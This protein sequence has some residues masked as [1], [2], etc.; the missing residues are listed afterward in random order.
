MCHYLNKRYL[1]LIVFLAHLASCKHQMLQAPLKNEVTSEIKPNILIFMTDDMTFSD[2]GPYG[3]KII[4]TPNLDAF[5]KQSLKFNYAFDSASM[6]APTRMALYTGLYPV[7]NGGHPNH[8]RVYDHVKSMPNY[9]RPL[10]YRVAITGKRHEAPQRNFSF[11]YIGGKHVAPGA[12][13][14]RRTKALN[15]TLIDEFMAETKKPWA[16]VV[17]S[18][19]PHGPWDKGDVNL[20]NPSEIEVPPDLVDTPETRKALQQ[21]Y[22][23]ITYA[24]WQFG[25]ILKFL[26]K[27]KQE[28]KTLVFFLSEQG[29]TFPFAKWTL[30]ESGVRAGIIARWPG[31]INANSE[32]DAMVQYVDLLPTLIEIAG[33]NKNLDLDGKSFLKVLLGDKKEH[34]QY[35]YGTH[36]TRGILSGSESYPIRSIRSKDYRLIWNLNHQAPFANILTDKGGPKDTYASWRLLADK[37]DSHALRRFKAYQQRPEFELYDMRE[38]RYETENLA[39]DPAYQNIKNQLLTQLKEWMQSQGDKGLETESQDRTRRKHERLYPVGIPEGGRAL[40]IV[41][42]GL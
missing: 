17:S 33:L 28:E 2:I 30:Y 12:P 41:L 22:A 1:V 3:N 6:C 39:Y 16:L 35:A 18:T 10:G 29:S 25:Q 31:L 23:E 9:L 5:A 32:T 8:S 37:G 11:D 20:Y 36:T 7:R 19:Q 4:K 14:R 15:L 24:D 26:K 34:R 27:H 42:D 38:N 40:D 21:Y 13:E